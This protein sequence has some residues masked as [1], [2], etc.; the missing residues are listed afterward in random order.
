MVFA[1]SDLEGIVR[2]I[3]APGPKRL[4][5]RVCLREGGGRQVGEVTCGGIPNM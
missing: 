4:P 2:L 5:G 3:W 1:L